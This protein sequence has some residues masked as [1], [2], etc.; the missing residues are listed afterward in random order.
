MPT[1]KKDLHPALTDWTWWEKRFWLGLLW[2]VFLG[3][4]ILLFGA[5]VFG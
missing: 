1:K 2:T 3:T 5:A 4:V